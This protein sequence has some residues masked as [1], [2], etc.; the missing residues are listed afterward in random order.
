MTRY[1]QVTYEYL[2]LSMFSLATILVVL[3]L[4]RCAQAET[5]IIVAPDGTYLGNYSANPY[6][7]DSI[8]NPY[9]PYGNPY[10]SESVRNPYGP[11]GNPYSPDSVTNPYAVPYPL[12]EQNR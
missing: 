6:D 4:A 1:L 10:Y 8:V 9:G 7:P 3:L 11:Y 12:K 5:P 2:F